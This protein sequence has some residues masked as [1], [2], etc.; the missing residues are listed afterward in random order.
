MT[1]NRDLSSLL[2]TFLAEG[3]ESVASRVVDEALLTVDHTRQR[4]AIRVPWRFQIMNNG[5]KLALGG[6][7]LA[8]L[9]IGGVLFVGG[10]SPGVG[11]GPA[12]TPSPSPS[13]SAA[14][15]S[16]S[17]RPTPLDPSTW[18]TFASV[19]H[20]YLVRLPADWSLK[21]AT[22]AWAFG[23]DGDTADSPTSDVATAPGAAELQFVVSSQ[24]LPPGMSEDGWFTNYLTGTES[25]PA[26]C[27]PPRAEWE[28]VIIDG[29]PAGLHGGLAGCNFT[30]AVAIIAGR[31]YVFTGYPSSSAGAGLVFDRALF[32]AILATVTV[33][34][35]AADDSPAATQAASP[36]P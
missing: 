5:L 31:A 18:Q 13:P 6:L 7:A 2:G 36:S 11:G 34:P 19:R 32:D 20:G 27:F 22:S 23:T 17:P 25:M 4:R 35:A 29:H 26:D 10:R 24:A 8:T 14:A 1:D 28:P 33:D 15:A 21:A 3:S 30:E 9:L 12:A 16:N